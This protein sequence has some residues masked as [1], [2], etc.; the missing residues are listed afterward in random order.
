MKSS[1]VFLVRLFI[2]VSPQHWRVLE[3]PSFSVGWYCG[4]Q[5]GIW[6]GSALQPSGRQV[7]FLNKKME[8]DMLGDKETPP[9]CGTDSSKHSSSELSG[10]RHSFHV[11][12]GEYCQLPTCG[13]LK[14][15][16]WLSHYSFL[17]SLNDLIFRVIHKPLFPK[18]FPLEI[19]R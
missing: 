3:M 17:V 6:I 7:I 14:R 9:C 11:N 4:Y 13:F 5:H 18:V 15:W 10:F 2:K 19:G 1:G 16:V 12:Q 8:E